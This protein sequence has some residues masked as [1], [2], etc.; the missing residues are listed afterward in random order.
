MIS[1]AIL[2]PAVIDVFSNPRVSSRLYG[3]DMVI[4]SENVRIPRIIQSFFMLS[5]MPARINILNSDKAR[6]ASMAGYLPMFSMCGVI[7]FMRTR[8]RSW[9]TKLVAVCGIMA[10]VPVLNS[11]FVMFNSSYY[12]RWYYMPILIMCLMTA[13]VIDENKAD[14]KKGFVPAHFFI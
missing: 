10:C 9:A 14:L 8:K 5:D 3:L 1:A 11:V 4:Y 12:A 2:I 7:A 13:K 6:W